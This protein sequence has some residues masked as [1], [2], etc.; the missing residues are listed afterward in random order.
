MAVFNHLKKEIDAKIVYYGPGISG[1]TTN[2]QFIH[3][4]LKPEQR[5]K[6]ISLATD[7]DRTLFFDFLPI[8]LESV[9]GFRTRFHLYTVPGQVYYGS[10][11]RAVLMGVDGIIFVADSQA[12]RMEAN[13][14]S[15]QDLSENLRYYGKKTEAVP[16]VFQFNK[17]DLPDALSVEELNLQINRFQA[18]YLESVAT[19]GRGVFEALTLACRLV[20][21]AIETGW[22]SRYPGAPGP[23][24]PVAPSGKEPGKKSVRAH[25]LPP[26]SIEE[27][28]PGAGKKEPKLEKSPA[29]LSLSGPD[30]AP[31]AKIP[32]RVSLALAEKK[33]AGWKPVAP[34]SPEEPRK[35]R[36]SGPLLSCGQPRLLSAGRL[37]IPLI[38]QTAGQEKRYRL[39]LA[40]DLEPESPHDP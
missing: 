21:K 24:P 9:R 31:G 35:E 40:F 25:H 2:L 37:E 6:M 13:L 12:E 11:R 16:L 15:L 3:Q 10:T 32:E 8:E 36:E 1:K 5:G 33:G 30:P 4:H 7:E 38:L 34:R 28:A 27:D 29:P 18:P 14:H 19:Q 39:R 20:L 26:P 17:R 22:P 23:L